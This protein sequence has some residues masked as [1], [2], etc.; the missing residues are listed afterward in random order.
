MLTD[1][2]WN[3]KLCMFDAVDDMCEEF[4]KLSFKSQVHVSL[5]KQYWYTRKTNH[6][7]VTKYEKK[8]AYVTELGKKL[9]KSE[10]ENNIIKYKK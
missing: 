9:L 8:S 1:I 5:Q 6:G 4:S 10:N 2:I 7:S 3:E